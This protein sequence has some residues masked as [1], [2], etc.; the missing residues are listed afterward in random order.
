MRTD[1]QGEHSGHCP[2]GCC[3]AQEMTEFLYSGNWCHCAWGSTYR[4]VRFVSP[5][6]DRELIF[7]SGGALSDRLLYYRRDRVDLHTKERR[8]REII[9]SQTVEY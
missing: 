7:N 8:R 4:M 6:N 2:A 9:I 3:I 5:T 1:S